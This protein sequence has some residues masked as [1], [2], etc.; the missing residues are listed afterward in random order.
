MKLIVVTD[1]DGTLLDHGSY[2]YAAAQEALTALKQAL[3]PL[4]L[5][6]SKTSA[7]VER[8]HGELSLGQT[9]AIVENGSGFFMPGSTSQKTDAAYQRIR[10]AL[11]ALPGELRAAFTG[12]GDVDDARVAEWTGLDLA[13]AGLARLRQFTEPGLWCGDQKQLAAFKAAMAQEGISAVQ[14]GRFLTLTLGRSKADALVEV[15]QMLKGDT[16]VALGDAP[17]DIE[18]LE[19]ADIAVIIRN[20][21]GKQLPVL[22]GEASGHRVG[23]RRCLRY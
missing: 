6:T 5:A 8:L 14:G 21:H 4:V 18:M 13:S 23:T 2:S 1:L 9:P 17:N 22:A 7:E 3:V 19:A 10:G 15:A 16:I 12:F 11:K 20:D